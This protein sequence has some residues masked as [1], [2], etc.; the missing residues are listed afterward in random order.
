MNEQMIRQ[1]E[2]FGL[3]EKEARVYLASLMLGPA[4]VQRIADQ[5][6]IKRVTTY[7]ILESLIHVGLVSQ[8]LRGKKTFFVAEDPVS[9]QR[10]LEKKQREI[11]D[12]QRQFDSI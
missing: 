8:S 5:A 12:Q 4:G 6:G 2:E 10:L 7:V 9:L 11:A 1:I 3:S